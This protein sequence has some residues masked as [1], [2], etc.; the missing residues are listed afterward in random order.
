MQTYRLQIHP[1]SPWVT[2]W[3]ADSVF[4]AICWAWSS[5]AG[6]DSFESGL[7]MFKSGNPPFVISDCFPEDLLPF[8]LG[9]RATENDKKLK[10][11][12][13]NQKTFREYAEGN[14][15]ELRPA[16]AGGDAPLTD[17][18]RVHASISRETNRASEGQLFE[19]DM[20]YFRS[21]G[22][23]KWL[24][25]YVKGS[26]QS[27]ALVAECLRV[28]GSRGFGRKSST[29]LGAFELQGKPESCKWLERSES[30]SGFMALSHFLPAATDPV[31]GYWRI[32]V[33][34]PKF[35]GD[36]VNEFLKG[37]IRFLTPGSMFRTEGKPK[38]WYGRALPLPRPGME[39]AIQYGFC[40][41][42]PVRYSEA[43]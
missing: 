25:L 14:L 41:A 17:Y 11:I 5:L 39:E 34:H 27:V 23:Y 19:E 37:T 8:P 30:H 10:A 1:L 13:V 26:E 43:K 24:S 20:H 7:R 18:S 35:Q 2:P 12:W 32:H 3:H 40:L 9:A 42:A 36:R 33:S 16:A 4:S 21:Q 29:G 6:R 38:D 28:T 31:D 15:D 22:G